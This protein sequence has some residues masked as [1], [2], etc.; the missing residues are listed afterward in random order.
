MAATAPAIEPVSPFPDRRVSARSVAGFGLLALISMALALAVPF[1]AY[2]FLD[3]AALDVSAVA[4]GIVLAFLL[5]TF[6][7]ICLQGLMPDPEMRATTSIGAPFIFDH[8]LVTL[9]NGPR[10]GVTSRSMW[11]ERL[12]AESRW[13]LRRSDT[14]AA[15]S[16]LYRF[17][18]YVWRPAYVWM[19]IQPLPL[20]AF[21]VWRH[22]TPSHPLTSL[23]G[24]LVP[25]GI[26]AAVYLL[27]NA[28]AQTVFAYALAAPRVR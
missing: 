24:W 7:L 18:L 22:G 13:L 10:V 6:V 12:R 26:L 15:E 21:W 16:K 25:M 28:P 23:R 8:R 14:Q 19:A 1:F 20:I 27:H 5:L 17:S 3:R 2:V 4:Y 11:A 9:G